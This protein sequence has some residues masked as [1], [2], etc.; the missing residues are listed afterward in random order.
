MNQLLFGMTVFFS[1]YVI[2]EVF[3]TVSQMDSPQQPQEPTPP[4]HSEPEQASSVPVAEVSEKVETKP[5]TERT[6]GIQLRD[7]VTG[8]VS[9]A[10]TNYR[11]AKKWI[12]EALVV[13]GLLDRVYKP[14]ELDQ[15]ASQKV[16]E[17]LDTF[18]SLEKY[19]V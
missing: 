2:H 9:I 4:H 13:E 17:A 14:S 11:F 1:I 15:V 8:D 10:P 7:P 12:K 16:K 6:L 5:E 18:K 3:E 19:Q